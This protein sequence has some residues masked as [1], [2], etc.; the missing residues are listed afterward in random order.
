MFDAIRLRKI[1]LI[2]ISGVSF[3]AV[4]G[5]AFPSVFA[6]KF[7]PH[8]GLLEVSLSYDYKAVIILILTVVACINNTFWACVN[9]KRRS[10]KSLFFHVL[11]CAKTE[12]LGAIIFWFMYSVIIFVAIASM[13]PELDEKV[14]IYVF[15]FGFPLIKMIVIAVVDW[16]SEKNAKERKLTVE[17]TAAFVSQLD[18]QGSI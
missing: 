1:M 9:R 2:I 17:Q 4:I 3:C 11:H 18:D 5:A 12:F 8:D 6:K 15:G 7:S 10:N 14:H 16:Y 13:D